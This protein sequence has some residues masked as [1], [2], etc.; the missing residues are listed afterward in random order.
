MIG[1]DIEVTTRRERNGALIL[2]YEE[3]GIPRDKLSIL[4]HPEG[5]QV[6][7][8]TG[9]SASGTF[10]HTDG[11]FLELN[12]QPGMCRAFSFLHLVYGLKLAKLYIERNIGEPIYFGCE[13]SV[14]IP[15]RFYEI[16]GE[17]SLQF[18]CS[19]EYNIYRGAGE[20]GRVPIVVGPD[21]PYR[22]TGWHIHFQHNP[23]DLQ[24]A[25]NLIPLL[26]ATIGLLGVA[27]APH[28]EWE[29]KRRLLYG[30]AG[31]YRPQPHGI[32]Y[33]VLSSFPLLH[34]TLQS[35]FHRIARMIYGFCTS[36]N[37]E[38]HLT[39]LRLFVKNYGND[40]IEVINTSDRIGARKLIQ[41]ILPIYHRTLDHGINFDLFSLLVTKGLRGIQVYRNLP[42][43]LLTSW[44][45][46]DPMARNH[47]S[48]GWED[49]LPK[50][51]GQSRRQIPINKVLS[52]EVGT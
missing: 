3:G 41:Q 18:G 32:E 42:K 52:K 40:I 48:F 28:P 19:P 43:D 50:L 29:K 49:G 6:N 8:V 31:A 37:Y 34:P 25:G 1:F 16:A 11:I 15:K 12:P 27:L 21:Y 14:E 10:I 33:R 20:K 24:I 23:N 30:G 51:L 47:D 9:V 7:N 35:L 36:F 46:C 2:P 39:S 22:S 38:T 44:T 5:A 17:E 45:Y 26:D 13:A 4:E